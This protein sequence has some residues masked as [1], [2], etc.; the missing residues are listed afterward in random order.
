M[1]YSCTKRKGPYTNVRKNTIKTQSCLITA[2]FTFFP[3][4]EILAQDSAGLIEKSYLLT[5]L[6]LNLP[7]ATQVPSSFFPVVMLIMTV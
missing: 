1:E 5:H 7:A 6:G 3:P 4:Q 2:F